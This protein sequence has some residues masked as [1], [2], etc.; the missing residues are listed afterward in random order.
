MNYRFY[1]SPVTDQPH[2]LDHGVTP[3]EAI[4]AFERAK[5]DF[6][7]RGDSRVAYGQARNG[8]YLK[9]VYKEEDEFGEIFIITAYLLAGN[10]LAAYRR[11]LR[12]RNG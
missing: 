8:R 1:F 9:V 4:E 5:Q 6:R 12:R 10:E 11:R 7:S 3:Q 2:V